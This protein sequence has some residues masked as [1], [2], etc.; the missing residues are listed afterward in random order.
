LV[1]VGGRLRE[2]RLRL[3]LSQPTFAALAG[4]TKGAQAKWEKNAASPNA[5]ALIAFAEAGA[6]VLYI[7]T[8]RR[9]NERSD[10]SVGQIEDQLAEIRR[11]IVDPGRYRIPG[12]DPVEAE[13]R[14]LER[15]A[16]ALA[17]MLRL[18]A[19]LL[20]TELRQEAESLNAIIGNPS[21]LAALRA[22]D[23]A[24]MRT[25]RRDMREQILG[26]LGETYQPADAVANLLTTL[27][28]EYGVP[29]RLLA[30]LVEEMRDDMAAHAAS[31]AA[32]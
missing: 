24:Q 19:S 32:T 21:Q 3:G 13:K 27:A 29:V 1:S 7:L 20:T 26:W 2:E 28:I 31:E 22:A 8:G 14:L 25:R 30:E 12:A 6:D 5:L 4:A 16:R 17:T 11:Q 15:H 23:H 10:E 18:D 9:A